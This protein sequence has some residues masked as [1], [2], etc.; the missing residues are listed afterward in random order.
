MLNLETSLLFQLDPAK[1]AEISTRPSAAITSVSSSNL[2]SGRRS[3]RSPHHTKPRRCTRRSGRKLPGK[4]STSFRRIAGARGILRAAGALAQD[5]PAAGCRERDSG[6]AEARAGSRADAV[7]AREGATGG[8]TQAHRGAGHRGLPE[9][10][11][12]GH[13]LAAARVE[14]HRGDRKARGEPQRKS[15][16]DR[17]F[18]TGLP[19]ILGEK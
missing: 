9:H 1:A 11:G 5:W 13:Q 10:R 18:Q 14:G 4:S 19:I 8:R 3:G 7:R 2:S 16:R 17:Q 15:R 12:A 6:E